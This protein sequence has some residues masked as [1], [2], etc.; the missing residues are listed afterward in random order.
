MKTAFNGGGGGGFNGGDSV[1]RRWR[2]GLRMGDDEAMVEID[3]SGG[4][5]RRRT[6]VFDSS[7]RQRW[8]LTFDVGDE[9]ELWQRWTI[10]T[11]FNGGGGG[12][13]QWWQQR[14]TVFDGIG[15]GLR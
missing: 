11:A 14:L 4:G 8:A 10:E 13:V 9:R 15:D 12:D 5:W 1:R 2:W 3:I 6:S 7:D